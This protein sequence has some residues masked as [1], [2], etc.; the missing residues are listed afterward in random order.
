[1]KNYILLVLL[2]YPVLIYSQTTI[3]GKVSDID[4]REPV[5]VANI[6]VTESGKALVIAYAAVDAQGRYEVKFTSNKDR[7]VVSVTGFDIKKESRTIRNES[8]TVDFLVEREAIELNEVKINPPK[9]RQLGDTLN[10]LVDSFIDQNDRTIGDVIRKLPGVQVQDD[11]S[12]LYQNKPINKFYIENMDMLQ[13]RYGIATNNIDANKISTVQVMENHQPIKALKDIDFSENAAINLKLKDSAKGILTATAQAGAGASP[14]LLSNELVAMLFGRSKQNMIM[15]KGDNSGRNISKEL[16]SL[17]SNEITSIGN[18]RLLSVQNP[19]PPSISM[20]RYLFNDAHMGTL[21]DLRKVGEDYTLTTNINYIF[22]RPEKSSSSY[23]EYFLPGDSVLIVDESVES[24]LYNNKLNAEFQL[25]ANTEKWYFNNMLKLEGEWDRERGNAITDDSVRQYLRNPVYG[26]SNSFDW[27]K[28]N[29]KNALKVNSYFG[30]KKSS[31]TLDVSPIL[32][33]EIFD[34]SSSDGNMIQD[35]DLSRFYTTNTVSWGRKSGKLSHNYAALFKAEIQHFETS[36]QA[37]LNNRLQNVPDSLSNNLRW[38]KYEWR[39]TPRFGYD[40]TSR[41]KLE[42]TLPLSYI[43]LHKNDK[44]QNEAANTDYLFL[45][46]GLFINY[47]ISPFWLA[48]MSYIY[49]N[50]IGDIYDAYNGYVMTSYRNLLRNDDIMNKTRSNNV[51][52]YINFKNPL[53]TLFATLHVSYRNMY[54]NILNDYEYRGILRVKSSIEQSNT[55]ESLLLFTR[56]GKELESLNSSVSIGGNYSYN[57]GSQLTQGM[58][59]DYKRHYLSVS[60]TFTVRFNQKA[61]LNYRM[62]MAWSKSRIENG[63]TNLPV[64][65]TMSQR[66]GLNVFPSKGWTLTASC[67]HFY[68]NGI[69][70]GSRSMWFADAS[71]KYKWKDIEFMLD[72]TNIFNTKKYVSSSYSDVG[73]YYYSY[74]IRPA[75]VLLRVRFKLI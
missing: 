52:G 9:I 35:M 42:L 15:Y 27:V 49:S 43:Y 71:A 69:E 58:V 59:S 36:L 40:I 3:K 66:I 60:P 70:S 28:V 29:D 67:E 53:T 7:V 73:R 23:S 21:N 14:L 63:N 47:R 72:Y 19:S 57:S 16:N 11:G 31:Q 24:I 13:G 68:N 61:N 46:P 4:T 45:N 62:N 50:S 18:G 6:T 17:Y 65:R 8:Q 51:I 26:I 1:M 20:Q 22:D 12:I 30:Y 75:E 37:R 5:D 48:N 38:N 33:T 55:T 25:N 39:F 44:K 64:M 41:I 34:V 32:Y 10:Y 54:N 56:I 2:I 74:N